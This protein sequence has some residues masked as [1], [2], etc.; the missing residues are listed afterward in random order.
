MTTV[1]CQNGRQPEEKGVTRLKTPL[2]AGHVPAPQRSFGG[3]LRAYFLAGVLVTAPISITLF[4][5]W[6]LVNA[7]DKSV[8]GLLP[9][10]FNPETY[11]PFSVPGLGVL[12]MIF[13]LIVIGWLTAGFLGRWLVRTGELVVDRIPAIRT[14]YGAVKQILET[15]LANQSDAFRE[16]V[17]V[18][19]PRKG[20]W[21]IGF[22]TGTTQGEVQGRIHEETVNVFLPTTPNPTSG[23]LLFLRREDLTFLDMSVEEG[24]KMVISA[25]IVVPP[26]P[27]KR[28]RE[29]PLGEP[30]D[31]PAV[32]PEE[33]KRA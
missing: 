19:Y 21:A 3:R 23:F 7:I 28:E 32:P 2:S 20:V 33:R 18:E 27:L 15:V 8:E 4:L 24:I 22:V 1:G 5:A 14:V 13:F 29:L 12:L 26:D 25:G 9:P 10:R 30:K 17:L 31:A 6:Q 16:C 11:L